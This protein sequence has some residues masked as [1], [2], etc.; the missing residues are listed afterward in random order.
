[1]SLDGRAG[2]RKLEN[3]TVLAMVSFPKKYR[4]RQRV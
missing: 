2:A 1:M 3:L 4:V